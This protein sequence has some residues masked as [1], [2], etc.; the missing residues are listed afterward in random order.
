MYFS[1]ISNTGYLLHPSILQRNPLHPNT[2]IRI[3]DIGCGSGIWLLDV[4]RQLPLTA[5]F[6]GFDI[7]PE[8]FTLP[9]PSNIHLHIADARERF[10]AEYHGKYDVVHLRLLV[11]GLEKDD[12]EVVTR[13]A[14]NLLKPGGA[15]QWEEGN[16][17]LA[18]RALRGSTESSVESMNLAASATFNALEHR[19]AYGWST[20]PEI[21]Q[22]VGIKDLKIDL[23]SSDRDTRNREEITRITFEAAFGAFRKRER[24]HRSSGNGSGSEKILELEK[25]VEKDIQSG[26]YIRFDVHIL[27][28][29]VNGEL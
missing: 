28:G 12:W 27:V 20:L 23:V 2:A 25:R 8:N 5:H 18:G 22:R 15:I 21:L 13:N 24:S 29:F 4:A 11:C 16:Y 3:A 14:I 17:L 7:S 9:L 19:F 26:A 1:P 6:D 10:S